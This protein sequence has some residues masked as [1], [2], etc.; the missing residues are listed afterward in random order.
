[1]LAAQRARLASRALGYSLAAQAAIDTAVLEITR[2]IVRYAM[3]GQ[4]WLTPV[5]RDCRPGLCIVAEDV[6]PG[7]ADIELALQDGYS[8]GQSLGLGLP[9]AR[10]MMDCFQIESVPGQ[11][12]RVRMVKWWS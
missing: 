2:N 11:G 10:R 12:T 3:V 8:T 5:C 6:G 1:M 9:G 4:M 7:I